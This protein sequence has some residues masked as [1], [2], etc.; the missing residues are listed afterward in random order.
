MST[1]RIK[2]ALLY[3]AEDRSF[4]KGGLTVENGKFAEIRAYE[5]AVD[6]DGALILPGLIDV[7]THGRG[8]FDFISASV[9]QMKEMKK[10]YAA[11]GVTTV[12]PTLASDTL[13]NMLDAVSRVKEAGF[14]A[15][16]IEGRYLNPKRRGAHNISHLAPLSEEEAALFAERAGAMKLHVTAAYELDRNGK[17]LSA[18]LA[19]GATAGLGHTDADFE[20][21]MSLVSQGLRSFTHLFNTMPPIHHRNGG[22]VLAGLLSDAYTEIICDGIHLAPETVSLIGKVKSPEKVVLITDSMEGTGCPDGNYSIAGN[23]VCLNGGKVYTSDGAIAGSTLE[24][25]DA[26]KNYSAFR[27]IPFAGAVSCATSNPAAMI[28]FDDIGSITPGKRADFLVLA[29]DFSLKEV[30][31][32]GEKR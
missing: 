14:R 21:A 24:L 19:H 30:Y 12:V 17:F 23:P 32:G 18:L 29:H 7:H 9:T 31:C 8:G 16:H 26:V 10:L 1:L 25:L 2:N 22:A 28:G 5:N 4:K 15:V 13:E 3:N 6:M 11:K 20:T 27:K